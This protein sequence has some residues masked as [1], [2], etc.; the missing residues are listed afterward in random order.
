MVRD[1]VQIRAEKAYVARKSHEKG[2]AE[3]HAEGLAEGLANGE[4]KA[5]L[6]TAR[7]F[8]AAGIPV[9]T[10]IQCTGLAREV[11]LEL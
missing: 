6:E 1:E 10:I 4:A 2:L 5:T 3:G 11:V 7:K 9:E 8:K